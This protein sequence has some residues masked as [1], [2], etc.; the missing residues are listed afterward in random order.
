MVHDLHQEVITQRQNMRA[1]CFQSALLFRLIPC[2]LLLTSLLLAADSV[3]NSLIQFQHAYHGTTK[4]KAKRGLVIK[5]IDDGVIKRGLTLA[6][7]K[8]MFGDDLQTF[9]RDPT[10]AVLKAVVFFEPATPPPN[11]LMSALR[12]GWYLDLAFSS[13]D[14]LERYSLGN[15]HK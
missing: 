10:N 9:R 14:R 15:L 1:P 8:L 4:P 2:W 13:D 7:A 6:D 3:N 5:A 12:Q 11:P